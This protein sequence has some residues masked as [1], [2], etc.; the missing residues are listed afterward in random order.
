MLLNPPPFFYDIY[1]FFRAGVFTAGAGYQGAQNLEYE[2]YDPYGFTY[3]SIQIIQPGTGTGRRD[4][5]YK[6]GT[7]YR[8]KIFQKDNGI[9]NNFFL[10]LFLLGKK[11]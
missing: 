6:S 11:E 4:M 1:I 8:Y 7:S 5:K 9:S 10:F 3:E 2:Y